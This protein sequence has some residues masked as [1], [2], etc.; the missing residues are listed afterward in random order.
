[1][2]DLGRHHHVVG[3]EDVALLEVG[4]AQVRVVGLQLHHVAGVGERD[5]DVALGQRLRVVVAGEAA[6]LALAVGLVDLLDRAEH[7]VEVRLR[8]VD[9]VAEQ[10]R[11]GGVVGLGEH[12]DLALEL[13]VE[14]VLDVLELAAGLLDVVADARRAR[15]PRQRVLALRVVVD[16]LE[17]VDEVREVRDVL[18]VDRLGVAEAHPAGGHVVGQRDDVAADR[19]LVLEL[20]ADLPEELEVVVDLLD[21]LD[22]AA[23][24]LV[25]V[26]EDLLVD[27]ERPVGERPVADL[28]L[29]VADRPAASFLSSAAFSAS[30]CTPPQAASTAAS[31][32][33]A[34]PE[35]PAR[36]MKPRRDRRSLSKNS[37]RARSIRGSLLT[38]SAPWRRRRCGGDSRSGRP[39][40]RVR[41]SP[42]PS[43][44]GS[45]R[46]RSAPR[47]PAP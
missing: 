13:R 21:V 5:V 2:L 40:A 9:A 12:R 6:E 31:P 34:R 4:E 38:R 14:Q 35:L 10:D 46:R 15:L 8:G 45:A 44:R 3:E 32:V 29:G 41:T 36:P 1:M 47:R 20:L 24:L 17:V 25:E 27:V 37:S 26:L 33:S 23:E 11:R 30:P 28:G 42:A 7:L 16:R 19:L 39:R 22:L 18:L 43:P